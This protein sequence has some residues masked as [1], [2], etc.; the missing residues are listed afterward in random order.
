MRPV[1]SDSLLIPIRNLTD[2]FDMKS[3]LCRSDR[4]RPSD[5]SRS[6]RMPS[7]IQ[8]VLFVDITTEFFH[9]PLIL[10]LR[11][12]WSLFINSQ[13]LIRIVWIPQFNMSSHQR[14]F[15]YHQG[16]KEQAPPKCLGFLFGFP[17]KYCRGENYLV[18]GEKITQLELVF[19][20]NVG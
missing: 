6:D 16:C 3:D 14:A 10:S 7:L 13:H 5:R 20:T 11:R 17:K 4:N 2:A 18:W 9:L 19:R 15:I 12:N 1:E 8:H